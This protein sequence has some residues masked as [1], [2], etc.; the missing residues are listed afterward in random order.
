MLK[1]AHCFQR[2]MKFVVY[3]WFCEDENVFTHT[4]WKSNGLIDR[5]QK[6]IFPWQVVKISQNG[7]KTELFSDC[8]IGI[9]SFILCCFS[10][11]LS[12][13][14]QRQIVAVCGSQKETAPD[15]FFFS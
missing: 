13:K 8:G 3:F 6:K 10:I 15:Y 11:L 9:G 12:R 2:K 1:E 4:Y 14:M 5:F 7:I